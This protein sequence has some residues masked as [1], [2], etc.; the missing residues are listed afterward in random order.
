MEKLSVVIPAYNERSTLL[1]LLCKVL[2]VDLSPEGL[3]KEI[4]VV[5][6]GS[7]DGTRD[8]IQRLGE[9]WKAVLAPVIKRKGLSAR[10]LYR[11]A[12]IRAFLH[13]QNK[14]KTAALRT[15]FAQVT[16]DIVIVQDA[17]LEYDPEDYH[18]ILKPI[19][20]GHADVV[21]GS[22]FNGVER[23]VLLYWHSLGNQFLTWLSNMVTDLNLT[24]METC[25][26]AFRADVIKAID[27]ESE[28]F[29][30]EPEITVKVTKLGCRIYE[31]PISYHGRGYDAGKKI[32]WKDGVETLYC[33]ARFS[34]SSRV[35][36]DEVL[37]V[38]LK[39]M[40]GLGHLNHAVFEA[41]QPWLGSRVAEA[42]SGHGN[43]TQYLAHEVEELIASDIEPRALDRLQEAFGEN[44]NVWVMRW[45]MTE[46]LPLPQGN[47]APDTVVA[48]NVLEHIEDDVAALRQARAALSDGGRLIVQ[49]PA[50]EALFSGVDRRLGH[51]RR[52]S[53]ASLRA[54][55]EAA[56]FEVENLQWFNFA[57]YYG[58]KLNAQRNRDYLPTGQLA[59]FQALSPYVLGLEKRLPLPIGL[60]LIAIARPA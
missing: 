12:E 13:P 40:S 44:D 49:V 45:D 35:V 55:L 16:G 6:D 30:F 28:R 47:A 53:E 56:G 19:L 41:I 26:K 21:Y 9:D 46:P 10:K 15:G 42:G 37:E 4:I 58:W 59:A 20:S 50:H 22:R 17:D 14:G 5:D 11:K 1:S 57:G 33:L 39:K 25:Y 36:H 32:S 38:T 29:G 7:T 43:V 27:I 31:V 52:Y 34:L 24:D 51:H 23:R 2:A 18:R 60:S 48:M 3:S 8:V 54:A